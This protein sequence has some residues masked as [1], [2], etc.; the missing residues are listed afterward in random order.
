MN[1]ILKIFKIKT[2]GLIDK[3]VFDLD[4]SPI[5]ISSKT[6]KRS[7][8]RSTHVRSSVRLAKG[9]FYTDEEKSKKINKLRKIKLP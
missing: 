2:G 4:Y 3:E 5:K 1:S 8:T 6:R 9:R 7:Q